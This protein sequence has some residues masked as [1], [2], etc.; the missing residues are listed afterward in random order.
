MTDTPTAQVDPVDSVSIDLSGRTALVT[1]AGSGIGRAT[2]LRL[3]RSGA[4]VRALDIN[5]AAVDEVAALTG[6]TGEVVDLSDL[7]AVDRLD[8]RADIVVNCAGIQ[9]V[10]PVHEFPTD[11]FS[12]ILRIM[13]EAPF[14]II[15][16][17]LPGMYE[18][19]WG[20]V[21]NVS[22]VHGLRAWHSWSSPRRSPTRWR[23]CAARPPP[24]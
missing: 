14:R 5:P 6:G 3:A 17:A 23:S 8:L 2:A 1:G 21:V 12:L 11:R 4:H 20:R 15:R 18:Q 16:G 9:H 10:A 13:L 22:S 24:R 19:Q 7:A